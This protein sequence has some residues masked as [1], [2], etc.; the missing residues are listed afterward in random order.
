MFNFKDNPDEYK[1][2]MQLEVLIAIVAIAASIVMFNFGVMTGGAF[3]LMDAIVEGLRLLGA[4]RGFSRFI[5][6]A[7]AIPALAGYL[8]MMF[9][10]FPVQ[11]A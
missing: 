4:S 5:G 2:L 9:N 3:F 10:R 11:V 7:I 6:T 8:I 1:R